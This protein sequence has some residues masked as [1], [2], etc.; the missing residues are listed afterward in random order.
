MGWGTTHIC[1]LLCSTQHFFLNRN[2]LNNAKRER[3]IACWKFLVLPTWHHVR[4][5]KNSWL[6]VILIV[7]AWSLMLP[8]PI[9]TYNV[10]HPDRSMM[11]EDAHKIHL[12][13]K[14]KRTKYWWKRRKRKGTKKKKTKTKSKWKWN[15]KLKMN[16]KFWSHKLSYSL[17][18][19]WHICYYVAHTRIVVPVHSVALVKLYPI[20]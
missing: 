9:H 13:N 17:K 20:T 4:N 12:R 18:S 5:N 14:C 2:W 16:E 7:A 11:D 15:V 19:I 1:A 3:K 10:I 6:I 8:M